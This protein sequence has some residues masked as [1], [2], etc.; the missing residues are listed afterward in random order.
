MLLVA[1]PVAG[2]ELASLKALQVLAKRFSNQR[3]AVHTRGPE[4]AY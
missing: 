1:T 3:G 4:G 2:F